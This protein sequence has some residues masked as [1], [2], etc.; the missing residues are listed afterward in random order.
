[1]NWIASHE[2]CADLT[3]YEISG[4]DS[5]YLSLYDTF[6]FFSFV[7]IHFEHVLNQNQIE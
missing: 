6:E 2:R 5:F 3:R 4:Y 7:V 1:M